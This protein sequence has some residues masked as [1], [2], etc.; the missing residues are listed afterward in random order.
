MVTSRRALDAALALDD[1]ATH[2]DH[3]PTSAVFWPLRVSYECHVFKEAPSPNRG[4]W[5][6]LSLATQLL[7][8]LP[9]ACILNFSISLALAQALF[10]VR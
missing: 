3:I 9:G 2:E 10:W 8:Y 7:F 4:I 6:E 5:D 1:L